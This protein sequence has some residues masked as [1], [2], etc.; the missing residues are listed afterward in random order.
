MALPAFAAPRRTR[1][2]RRATRFAVVGIA[3]SGAYFAT[4]WTIVGLLHA[5]PILS[6]ALAFALATLVSYACNALWSF[7]SD[8]SHL[9]AAKYALVA[10][11]GFM[12]NLSVA[13][14]AAYWG[15]GYLAASLVVLF[16]LPAIN[17]AASHLWI[18]PEPCGATDVSEGE[19]WP[20]R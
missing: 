4:M 17:F 10:A 1:L 20:T 7:G 6:A 12:V 3:T 15:Y 8:L 2:L 5:D 9:S 14:G 13:A 16:V 18:F 11:A 19:T